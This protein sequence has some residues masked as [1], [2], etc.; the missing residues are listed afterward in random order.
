VGTQK[1]AILRAGYRE[2]RRIA[3]HGPHYPVERYIAPAKILNRYEI[4][5]DE[6]GDLT[7]CV[8]TSRNDWLMCLWS[9]V[10]FLIFSG[11]RVPLLIYSDGTLKSSHIKRIKSVFPNARIVDPSTTDDFVEQVLSEFPNCRHFRR[12]QPC[13][14]RIIDLPVLCNSKFILM[15]DSD[16]LFFK[17]PDELVRYLNAEYPARFV[18]ERDIQDAYFESRENI[19]KTFEVDVASSVNCGIMLADIEKFDYARIEGW[20]GDASIG[21][22]P[23]AEQTL[24]AMYAGE[25]RTTF[26]S[27]PYNVNISA[28]IEANA[29]MKHY[30]KPIRDFIYTQGIPHLSRCLEQLAR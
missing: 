11:L 4:Q 9:L 7:L 8:L 1:L 23:W 12:T 14:R 27:E 15:L 20:L 22:H 21:R 3:K 6:S 16:I 18:F 26:L 2:M 29:V 24:W 5:T 30:I 10:S 13:A 17:R 19:R 25:E 28:E